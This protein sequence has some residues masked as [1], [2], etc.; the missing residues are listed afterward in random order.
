MN[1]YT[2]HHTDAVNFNRHLNKGIDNIVDH[3]TAL[4]K[5]MLPILSSYYNDLEQYTVRL[6]EMQSDCEV[7]AIIND[8]LACVEDSAYALQASPFPVTDTNDTYPLMVNTVTVGGKRQWVYLMFP[9]PRLYLAGALAKEKIMT[10]ALSY[11][12]SIAL[13]N[14]FAPLVTP[15]PNVPVPTCITITENDFKAYS[16]CMRSVVDTSYFSLLASQRDES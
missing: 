3:I 9:Y 6:M 8:M 7:E 10:L 4:H 11:R 12:R 13:I 5:V 16:A 1:Y 2:Y 14:T 15:E